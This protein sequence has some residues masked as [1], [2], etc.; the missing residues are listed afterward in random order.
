MHARQ[1][2]CRC[3]TP[4][5]SARTHVHFK[6]YSV[7]PKEV[8][9]LHRRMSVLEETV[10][11]EALWRV[12]AFADAGADVLFIDALESW[13]EMQAFC[14]AG[15][16]AA[17]LPKVIQHPRMQI[18]FPSQYLKGGLSDADR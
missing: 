14:S 8:K 18:A 17:S 1:S 13:D 4:V 12:A 10:L 9:G 15:G 2:R 16:G 6:Q 5:R 7:K 3:A 11:Q